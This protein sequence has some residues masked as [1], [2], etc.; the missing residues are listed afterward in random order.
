MKI[1][2]NCL[3]PLSF[4]SIKIIIRISAF[5]FKYIW[6]A[7]YACV[8][9]LTQWLVN[10]PS[11]QIWKSRGAIVPLPP[12]LPPLIALHYDYKWTWYMIRQVTDSAWQYLAIT[13]GSC[14]FLNLQVLLSHS[15]DLKLLLSTLVFNSRD[16]QGKLWK[17]IQNKQPCNIAFPP[18]TS[19]KSIQSYWLYESN[20]IAKICSKTEVKFFEWLLTA[21]VCL[22]AWLQQLIYHLNNST[23]GIGSLPDQSLFCPHE[24]VYLSCH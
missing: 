15:C 17:C 8:P 13:I 1:W 12:I 6:V 9:Q 4:V 5:I 19:H 14:L 11:S 2:S 10:P 3:W 7:L 21:R 22:T 16:R 18:N 24:L 20:Q 23:Y